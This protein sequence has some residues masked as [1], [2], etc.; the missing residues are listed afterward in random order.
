VRCCV[1]L[2][3]RPDHELGYEYLPEEEVS[4][5]RFAAILDGITDPA[6]HEAIDLA[7]LACAAGICPI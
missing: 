5:G 7:H 4:A 2:P 1:L 6:L 3:S